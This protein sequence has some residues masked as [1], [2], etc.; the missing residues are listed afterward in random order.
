MHVSIWIASNAG[1]KDAAFSSTEVDAAGN[2]YLLDGD[3][4]SVGFK[5][6]VP[7]AAGV[8]I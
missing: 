2:H 3:C 5:G 4:S 8:M 6:T 7:R 1:G